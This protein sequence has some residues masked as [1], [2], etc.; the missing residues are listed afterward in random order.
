M[1]IR[2]STGFRNGLLGTQGIKELLNGGF[3]KIYTGGQPTTADDAETGTLLVT[4]GTT[5]GVGV[6]DGLVLGTAATGVIPKSAP[7]WSGTCA[8]AGVAGYFRFYGTGGTTGSS[9]TQIRMDGNVGVTGSDMVL[10][11]TT[12]AAG[13]TLTIDTATITEPAS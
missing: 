1:A 5:S 2:L 6:N 4:V 10:S 13:A 8:A 9:N 11:N 7:V 12:L 3:I